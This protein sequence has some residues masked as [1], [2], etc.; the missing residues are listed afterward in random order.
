MSTSNKIVYRILLCDDN[1]HFLNDLMPLLYE[2]VAECDDFTFD[3][4]Y[5]MHR[6]KIVS[7]IRNKTYDLITLDVCYTHTGDTPITVYEN[8]RLAVNDGMYGAELYISDI[9]DRINTSVTKVLVV[10]NMS[11]DV[12]KRNF[13]YD[14]T[15]DYFCK[16]DI[17]PAQLANHIYDYFFTNRK[18]LFNDVFVV[19]GHNASMHNSV[20]KH[21]RQMNI[22]S[23]DLNHGSSSGLTSFIDLLTNAAKKSQC[24][25]IL[26]SADDIILDIP[27]ME[28]KYS[29]RSNVIFKMGLFIG[30]IGKEKIIV[31]HEKHET[32][33][34]PSDIQGVFY[35]EYDELKPDLWKNELNRSL[36]KIGF[37]V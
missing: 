9:K 37:G 6:D 22:C 15:L 1:P 11:I 5:A 25:I 32:F 12:L 14:S 18:S 21:L 23:V 3:I 17:S 7:S 28:M 20:E 34:F 36:R 30:K 13:N 27:K 16:R 2:S 24:A 8:L 26:L 33:E 29:A 4:D 10:S 31:L 19:Y 35:I